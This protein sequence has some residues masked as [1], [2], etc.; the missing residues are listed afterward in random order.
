MATFAGSA[1]TSSLGENTL[2]DKALID[3]RFGVTPP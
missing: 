1:V 3:L 2:H